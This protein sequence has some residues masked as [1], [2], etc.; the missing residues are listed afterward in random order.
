MINLYNLLQNDTD[1]FPFP[2][3]STRD[4][5]PC[6][7]K[8]VTFNFNNSI[9]QFSFQYFSLSRPDFLPVLFQIRT[10]ES[11]DLSNNKL[12]SIPS[13]FMTG[14]GNLISLGNNRLNG[15]I[16][17]SSFRSLPNLIYL[18]LHNNNLGGS[19]PPELGFCKNLAALNL[20]ENQLAGVLPVELGNLSVLQE[21]KLQAN[22]LAGEMPIEMTGLRGL[23]KLNIS[24]N[25]L[26]GSIPSA[27][28]RLHNLN[29][30]EQ[31][32]GSIISITWI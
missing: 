20:A 6:P 8:G 24:W 5:N 12:S 22:N 27:I 15:T 28:S 14:C 30:L 16:P 18:E 29:N 2:W 31:F 32:P 9:T 25:S 11:I 3:N 10:L 17:S 26:N 23:R 4:R 21:L 7:W 13:G 19:I 1:Q